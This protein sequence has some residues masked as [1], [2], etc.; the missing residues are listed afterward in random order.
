MF[1]KNGEGEISVNNA[2][3]QIKFSLLHMSSYR[4]NRNH[5]I[6]IMV[7]RTTILSSLHTHTQQVEGIWAMGALLTQHSPGHFTHETVRQRRE[8][9][10]SKLGWTR[11]KNTIS[12]RVHGLPFDVAPHLFFHELLRPA[13]AKLSALIS[14]LLPF[15]QRMECIVADSLYRLI[16]SCVLQ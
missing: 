13:V 6:T 3:A 7:L 5:T 1:Q 15:H 9:Y 16:W 12:L 2:L 10:S 4:I 8:S 14:W 11:K